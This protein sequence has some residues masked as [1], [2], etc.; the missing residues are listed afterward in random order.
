MVI[1]GT[2]AQWEH[3]TGMAFPETGRYV[4]PEALDLIDID[5]EKDA[6]RYSEPNLWMRHR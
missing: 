3:W 2:V 4:V 5:R 1:S 6:G